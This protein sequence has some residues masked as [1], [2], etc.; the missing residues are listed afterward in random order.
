MMHTGMGKAERVTDVVVRGRHSGVTGI[1]GAVGWTLM[2][3][4]ALVG[5]LGAV[6]PGAVAA[7]GGDDPVVVLISFAHM[8][9]AAEEA[10]VRDYGGEI[11]RRHHLAPVIV[12]SVPRDN[13]D[14]LR[15]HPDVVSVEED[16]SVQASQVVPWGGWTA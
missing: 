7:E 2:V 13:L 12:A 16:V 14:S 9:G 8:P 1:R 15:S 6:G 10:L 4:L 5:V 11:K 3:L